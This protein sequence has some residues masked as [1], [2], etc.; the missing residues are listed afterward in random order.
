MAKKGGNVSASMTPAQAKKINSVKKTANAST[1]GANGSESGK[2]NK[3]KNG[4]KCG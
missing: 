4:K 1:Q 2:V 3:G